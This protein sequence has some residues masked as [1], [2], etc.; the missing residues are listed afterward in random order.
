M[1]CF[2]PNADGVVVNIIDITEVKRVQMLAEDAREYAENVAETVRE[3]L[4]ILDNDLRVVSGNT[5]IFE[6]F[7]ISMK[8]SKEVKIYELSNGRWNIPELRELL[9]KIIP[10]KSSFQD[11][12]SSKISRRAVIACWSLTPGESNKGAPNRN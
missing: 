6:T 10:E 2:L 11:F 1:P 12:R 5:A 9:E 3:P 7:G 8:E 4:L